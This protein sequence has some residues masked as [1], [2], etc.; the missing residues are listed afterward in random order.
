MRAPAIASGVRCDATYD[1]DDS[2]REGFFTAIVENGT[3]SVS[4]GACSDDLVT[5]WHGMDTP[6]Y[7]CGRHATGGLAGRPVFSVFRGH[8]NRVSREVVAPDS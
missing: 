6:A 1:R 8:R 3:E 4:V 2:G 7:A 5:I